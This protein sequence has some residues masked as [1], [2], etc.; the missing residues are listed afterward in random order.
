M[1][2]SKAQKGCKEW[3]P[4]ANLASIH[5][6]AEHDKLLKLLKQS[7]VTIAWIGGTDA[8][9]E[10]KWR[11]VDGSK[12]SWTKWYPGEPNNLRGDEHCMHLLGNAWVKNVWND[13]PCQRQYMYICQL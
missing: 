8:G 5:S 9:Q 3:N 1:T 2:H 6:Q 12:F 13:T 10:G 4:K 11:W 7:D